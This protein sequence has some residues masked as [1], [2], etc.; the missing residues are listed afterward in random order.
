[1]RGTH[2]GDVICFGRSQLK[3]TIWISPPPGIDFETFERDW[4]TFLSILRSGP[5]EI[6]VG[7]QPSRAGA[8]DWLVAV[9]HQARVIRLAES[10][11]IRPERR[12]LIA[13]E[14]P[15]THPHMYSRIVN[16]R[17]VYQRIFAASRVWAEI[18]GGESFLWPQ[19]ALDLN[20]M[21]TR[22]A[23]TSFSATMLLGNKFSSIPSSLYFLRRAVVAGAA[24][25]DWPLLVSGPQWN[26]SPFS[27]LRGA[28]RSIVKGGTAGYV[29][30]LRV[31]AHHLFA[32]PRLLE[33]G[34]VADK[35]EFLRKAPVSLILE[36]SNDYVSEKLID[37]IAAG[38]VPIYSGPQLDA[39]EFPPEIAIEVPD[40]A[41]AI[42]Q[43]AR[44]L[45]ESEIQRVFAAGQRW[46]ASPDSLRH[47]ASVV[48]ADL[49]VRV[50][51]TLGLPGSVQMP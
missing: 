40:N 4:S 24:R 49:A 19:S 16:T 9:N 41:T 13:L 7:L 6:C 3:R 47:R 45:E 30:N 20:C 39:F 34:W 46:L 29:P 14:P 27:R 22:P 48:L 25:A 18:L 10:I 21:E 15:A 44:S 50:E 5:H 42:L 51:A 1:V 28:A 31:T 32:R 11:R 2:I 37:A 43:R 23:R 33:Q 38:V 35:T 26:S 36:N 12:I 8:D 17:D